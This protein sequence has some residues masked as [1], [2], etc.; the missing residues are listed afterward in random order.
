M[1]FTVGGTPLDLTEDDVVRAVKE[2]EPEQIREHYVVV[3][4]RHYPVTPVF[5]A[6]TG[7][8]RLDFTTLS[9][10]RVLMRLGFECRRKG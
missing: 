5:G 7:M 2:I 9:A 6:T 10:R 1:R 8:D 3:K 4:R